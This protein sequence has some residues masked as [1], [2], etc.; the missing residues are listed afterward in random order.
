MAKERKRWFCK[1]DLWFYN[2]NGSHI[3]VGKAAGTDN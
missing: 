2:T 3:I 1:C